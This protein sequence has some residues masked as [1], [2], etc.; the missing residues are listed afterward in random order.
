VEVTPH[1]L[2]ACEGLKFKGNLHFDVF[3]TVLALLLLH[4]TLLGQTLQPLLECLNLCGP[5]KVH[6]RQNLLVR[7]RLWRLDFDRDYHLNRCMR[8]MRAVSKKD[9]LALVSNWLQIMPQVF[10]QIE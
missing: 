10:A 4:L 3:R 7:G 8:V 2:K 9:G 5:L 6:G 1:F